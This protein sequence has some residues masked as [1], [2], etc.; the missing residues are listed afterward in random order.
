MNLLNLPV[1]VKANHILVQRQ[2]S[3]LHKSGSNVM[4]FFCLLVLKLVSLSDPHGKSLGV[5]T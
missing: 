2:E 1:L 4:Q 5:A 3:L